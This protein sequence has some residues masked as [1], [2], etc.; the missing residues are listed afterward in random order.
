[1]QKMVVAKKEMKTTAKGNLMVALFDDKNTRFSGFLPELKDILEGDTIEAEIEVDGKY[2][3]IKA[4]KFLSHGEAPDKPVGKPSY[5]QDSPEKRRSIER[6]TAAH[7]AFANIPAPDTISEGMFLAEAI[8]QWIANGLMPVSTPDKQ[9]GGAQKAPPASV[10]HKQA[11][12]IAEITP[13][14]VYANIKTLTS[15][16]GW[17]ATDLKAAFEG[18]GPLGDT[19]SE[20]LKSLSLENLLI[21]SGRVNQA[22]LVAKAK[23]LGAK[24]N[25]EVEPGDLPF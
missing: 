24:A 12:S 8:Y 11:E 15:N 16:K 14:S 6:Q 20:K 2:N 4:V 13:E 18:I 19:V 10:P 9:Q 5:G 1:M 17:T 25:N 3:N 22:L 23:Q 21:V 7:I